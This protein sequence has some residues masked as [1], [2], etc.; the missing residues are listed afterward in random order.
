MAVQVYN[1]RVTYE[2]CGNRIWRDIAASSNYTL[3]DL[4]C[5]ILATFGTLAYHLFEMSFKGVTY[6][7]SEKEIPDTYADGNKTFALL[8]DCKLSTLGM[9]IGESIKMIYDFGCEQHFDIRLTGIEPMPKGHGRAY[10]KILA[11]EGRS[12]VDDMPAYELLEIIKKID[13]GESSGIYYSRHGISSQYKGPEWDYR[14]YDLSLD[15]LLFKGETNLIREGYE[16]C[17]DGY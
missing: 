4:G 9:E 2:E 1:F 8:F 17:R 10:P 12:I 14:G 13:A 7:L 3:A 11:G 5:A 16:E 6:F 15:N